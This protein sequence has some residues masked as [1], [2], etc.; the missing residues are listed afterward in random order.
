[1]ANKAKD[2]ASNMKVE[3]NPD[4]AAAKSK[5]DDLES[6]INDIKD[7]TDQV[8]DESV[9]KQSQAQEKELENKKDIAQK[10]ADLAKEVAQNEID[11]AKKSADEQVKIAE[12]KKEKL[13]KIADA[14]T[15][16][17]KNKLTEEKNAY[18]TTAQAELTTM[19]T[20]YNNQVSALEKS[21]KKKTD[22]IDQQIKDLETQSTDTS[23][24]DTRTEYNNKIAVLQNEMNNSASYADRQSYALQIKDAQN[25]LSKQENQWSIDDQKTE[26]ET[27]KSNLE[28]QEQTKKDSLE[29]Q[30]NASKEA[31]EK[32]IK[33]TD[34]YYDKLLEEDSINA[35]AR[36][37]LLQ[38]NSNELVKLLQS[39]NPQ[40]QDAGQSLADSLLSGLNSQKQN[41]EQAVN[42]LVDLRSGKNYDSDSLSAPTSYLD[43][44]T[45]KRV[46][47]A[48]GTN[49]NKIAGLYNTNEKGFE[50]NTSGDVAYVSQ[51]AAIKNHM[52]TQNYIDSLIGTKI[53]DLQA[54]LIQSQQDTIKSMFG[55][56]IG[57][58]T[59]STNNY[60]NTLKLNIENYHQHTN[61]DV[62]SLSNE[63]GYYAFKQRTY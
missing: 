56:I 40:W 28:V 38:G 5:L 46:G 57:N 52:E 50:M 18:D 11:Q 59:N 14:V 36:Y 29:K 30:Y 10:E 27:E 1:M 3:D 26:L 7:Q 37:T 34:A 49:Y 16:A 17:I 21:L 22:D 54:S 31:K 33:N 39:Y 58:T 63:M 20:N 51:G 41:I 44:S 23:R 55:S 2:N 12:D 42:E 6:Q 48:T 35:Q 32:E 24:D 53:S 45:N 25:E 43:V 8:T 60:G 9:K 47:Y 61:Q 19:E 13:T 4:Y 62:E 15:T